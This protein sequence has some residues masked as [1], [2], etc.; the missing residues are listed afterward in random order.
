MANGLIE[1]GHVSAEDWA[2]ALGAAL[3]A[4]AVAGRA[5]TEESYFLAALEAL[6]Y[7]TTQNSQITAREVDARK[8][9]WEDAY[10]TTPHGAPVQIQSDGF[11]ADASEGDI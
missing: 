3:R 2:Q 11:D 10:R 1:N 6:E 4:G 5:D 9:A 7:V 8:S